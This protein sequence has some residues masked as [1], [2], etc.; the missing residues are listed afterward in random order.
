MLSNATFTQV[1]NAFQSISGL[2]SLTAADEFFL[3]NSMNR[4]ARRAYNESNSWPRY[5]VVSEERELLK[6]GTALLVEGVPDNSVSLNASDINGQYTLLGLGNG[7]GVESSGTNVY[8][9]D[10]VDCIAY[11]SGS[12]WVFDLG[13]TAAEQSDGT[14]V[15]SSEVPPELTDINGI[16]PDSIFDV[17][18]WVD[19]LF[20]AVPSVVTTRGTGKNVVLYEE[21]GKNTIGEPIRVHR[22]DA[23]LNNSALEYEFYADASGLNILNAANSSD[24]K[25]YVTYKKLATFDF[26]PD[27]T[28]IPD[29]FVDYMIHSALADFYMGDGQTDKVSTSKALA[30]EALDYELE[31]AEKVMNNNTVNKRFSTYVNRQSR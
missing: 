15:V 12:A 16:T 23:F 9:H 11:N 20:N 22:K 17:E 1:K 27:S 2:E 26:N 18:N 31:R 21:V 13:A 25:A 28:D 7:S 5:L 30:K 29:E 24:N 3:Q 10:A 19:T 6:A 8:S 4:S 14:Y